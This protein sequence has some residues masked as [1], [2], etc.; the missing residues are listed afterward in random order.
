MAKDNINANYVRKNAIF[1][2]DTINTDTCAELIG[3]LAEMVN[4]IKNQPNKSETTTLKS[5]Y[6][7][8]K[9]TATTVV[10]VF[11]N[12]P[13]GNCATMDSIMSFLNIARSKGAIIRTTVTGR[14]ASCASMIAIQGTHGFRIMYQTSYNLVHYGNTSLSVSA[15]GEVERA[16]K[17]ENQLR[18]NQINTYLQFT[19]MTEKE[20]K[21][22]METEHHVF[23]AQQCL[24]KNMCDWILTNEGKFIT[25]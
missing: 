11:I 10:D 22:C 15:S 17:N 25:R 9:P 21:K 23:S 8:N 14:A 24:E 5:P 20:V 16:A 18:K 19:D 6:D 4:N 3:D 7:I 1:L 12:S 2:Y 13:G